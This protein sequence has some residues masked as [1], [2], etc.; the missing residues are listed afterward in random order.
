MVC[1]DKNK[2]E[3]FLVEIIL[4]RAFTFINESLLR[5]YCFAKF[6]LDTGL[7]L[8]DESYYR[9]S[10][11]NPLSFILS[12]SLFDSRELSKLRDD[13]LSSEEKSRIIKRWQKSEE[14]YRG[15]FELTLFKL[16]DVELMKLAIVLH[17]RSKLLQINA[18]DYLKVQQITKYNLDHEHYQKLEKYIALLDFSVYGKSYMKAFLDNMSGLFDQSVN[19]PV[20]TNL[21]NMSFISSLERAETENL[22]IELESKK[23]YVDI[24][25]VVRRKDT[26]EII[27]DI[28][29]FCNY[30]IYY[31]LPKEYVKEGLNGFKNIIKLKD[32]MLQIGE[33]NFLCHSDILK[34]GYISSKGMT[35]G[36][37]EYSFCKK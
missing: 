25:Y 12:S 8:E 2:L 31:R 16:T 37:N 34:Y 5:D 22:I 27:G 7:E 1:L 24:S 18:L 19:S 10:V 29:M 21:Q 3:L 9:F 33:D 4:L 30:K 15:D 6:D 36:L 35:E 26:K 20:F 32:S 23:D 11:E 14:I 28:T 13:C 17:A